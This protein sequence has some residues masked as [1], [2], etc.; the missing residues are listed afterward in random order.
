MAILANL[1]ISIHCR[2]HSCCGKGNRVVHTGFD[3]YEYM[4]Y[5]NQYGKWF[6]YTTLNG[7]IKGNQ[8]ANS[9]EY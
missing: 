3:S 1:T 5:N 8:P 9:P 6:P 2:N 7:M 4:G